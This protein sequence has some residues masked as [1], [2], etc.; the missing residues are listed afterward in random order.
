[1]QT[2]RRSSDVIAASPVTTSRSLLMASLFLLMLIALPAPAKAK[3]SPPPLPASGDV[4]IAGGVGSDGNVT[5]KAEFYSVSFRRFVTTGAMTTARATHQSDVLFLTEE[6]DGDTGK[7]FMIGGFNGSATSSG[8][9]IAFNVVVLDNF[10]LYD[11]ATGTFAIPTTPLLNPMT[12]ARAFFPVIDIP[13]D[14]AH[15]HGH[16]LAIAGMCNSSDLDSCRSADVIHPDDHV[17]QTSNPLVG[18]MMHTATLL[19]NETSVLVTGGFADLAGT[20]LNTAEI[21]D[22]NT[23][24]FTA[25]AN[26]NAARAGQTATILNDGTVLIAGGFDNTG[27]AQNSAEIFTPDVTGLVGTFTP[28][29]VPMHDS[30]AWHT[31]TLLGDGT[32]LLAGGFNGSATFALSGGVSGVSGSWTKS[33][34]SVLGTAEIYDPTTETFTCVHG[35]VGKSGRCRKSMKTARIDQTATVLADGDVLIAGGFT[36]NKGLKPVSSAE[37]FHAGKFVKT[38]SMKTARAWHSAIALP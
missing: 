9:S 33:S 3:G 20:A 10:E 2:F 24:D 19:Q 11:P 21:L 5:T 27:A 15:I 25:I 26:M 28:V 31:A 16:F 4:L 37:L 7:I 17:T 36:G 8:S 29:P 14:A 32:V 18:R 23:D 6:S 34:G 30:R 35:T 38:A 22:T 13:A 1:M 12:N